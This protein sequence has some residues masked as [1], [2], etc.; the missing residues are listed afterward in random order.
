MENA[1]GTSIRKLLR[2]RDLAALCCL[3][4]QQRKEI[5]AQTNVHFPPLFGGITE[6]LSPGDAPE[7]TLVDIHSPL[8]LD[9]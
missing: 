4:M 1:V 3:C 6:Q 9:L 8:C 2:G 7:C 5:K